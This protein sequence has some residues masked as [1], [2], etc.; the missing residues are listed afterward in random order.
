MS[1][2][3]LPVRVIPCFPEF[4][5]P[6]SLNGIP[7]PLGAEAGFA[8]TSCLEREP[9]AFVHLLMFQTGPSLVGFSLRPLRVDR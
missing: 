1:P 4:L 7:P 3:R 2:L 9:Y 5:A 6:P 8:V